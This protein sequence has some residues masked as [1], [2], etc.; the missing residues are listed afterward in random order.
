MKPIQLIAIAAGLLLARS[1]IAADAAVCSTEGYDHRQYAVFIDEPT[2]Y[3]FIKTPCG[4]HFVR[5]IERDKVAASI[6]IAQRTPLTPT[7]VDPLVSLARPKLI[8]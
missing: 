3:A 2:G 4:W 5:Q 6:Q 1:G 8:D 7:P